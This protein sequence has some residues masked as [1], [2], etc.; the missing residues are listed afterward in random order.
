MQKSK[1]LFYIKFIIP[2]IKPYWKA[3][4]LSLICTVLFTISN[5]YIMPLVN[6][7]T[8]E[9]K[10]GNFD[11][12]TNHVINASILFLIRLSCKFYQR[13]IM[14]KVS[15]KILL[16]LRLKLYKIIHYLPSENYNE[17]KHGDI[18]SRILD[19]CNKIKNVIFLN[20]ESLLP[21][22]LTLIAVIG[23]LFYLNWVLSLVSFL[24][25]P[26]FILTLNYFSKRLRKVS[27]QLQQNTAD[28]TQ[29]IQESL[30]NMKI[31]K[32]YTSENRNI[33]KFN[34]IQNR[35]LTGYIKEIKYKIYREQIDAYSQYLIFLV[36]I[37]FGGYL[38]LKGSFSTESLIAFFTGIILLVEPSTI[39]TKIYALTFQVTAS[40]ER[41]SDFLL[42]EN[43]I[44]VNTPSKAMNKTLD[45]SSIKFKSVHFKYSSS[46]TNIINDI[47]LE[48]NSGDFIGIVGASGSGKSTLINLITKFYTPQSGTIKIDGIDINDIS[49][50]DIRKNIA[51]VPQE[52]LL[53]K[54]SILDNCRIGNPD[55]SIKEIINA[56]KLA[57]AWEFV[58][59]L[60]DQLLTKIGTQGLNLS[61]GQRQ[62]LS[63]ARAIVSNPKLLIL[64]E[65]TSALDSRSE[66]KIQESI[67]SLKGSF[68]IIVIAHRFST[69]KDSNKILV[70]DNGEIKETGNHTDLLNARSYY[71]EL[72]QKQSMQTNIETI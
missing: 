70:I 57:N 67:Q 33:E 7:I 63:I 29:M 54:S 62:R 9:I 47:S 60:P 48:I 59:E 55:A 38:T 49:A 56:L 43:I 16:D 40:I 69:I 14:E 58:S 30:T 26:I 34:R 24:G 12:F 46:E 50:N 15:Y 22:L 17:T 6:D 10:N 3:L 72:F 21:N 71:Y 32:I 61:G 8:R 41:I 23:Y 5:V 27:K 66:S 28:L 20:F 45:F 65:A 53:F 39:I 2:F 11:Y 52:S 35:Y 31:L 36:I 4:I 18:L 44:E 37:W 25:V 1:F 68:T 13:F 51:L 19:D 42:K 64:D